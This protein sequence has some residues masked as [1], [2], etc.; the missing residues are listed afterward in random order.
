MKK[1]LVMLRNIAIIAIA[2][3]CIL[4]VVG[5]LNKSGRQT[6]GN[7]SASPQP[8]NDQAAD[9]ADLPVKI[10]PTR[11]CTYQPGDE[12]VQVAP[13]T[14][15]SVQY[16]LIATGDV[17]VL[18]VEVN[19]RKDCSGDVDPGDQVMHSGDAKWIGTGACDVV[20]GIRVIAKQGSED[21]DVGN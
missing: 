7:S 17:T 12:I 2:F 13:S 8:Q 6:S 15:C 21:F 18:R 20:N 11:S 14:S 9:D 4:F 3:L 1:L 5:A 16:R 10:V 19:G